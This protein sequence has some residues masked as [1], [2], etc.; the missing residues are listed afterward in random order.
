ML[1]DLFAYLEGEMLKHVSAEKEFS[2]RQRSVCCQHEEIKARMELVMK[3]CQERKDVMSNY[4]AK[5]TE[6]EAELAQVK[7]EQAEAMESLKSAVDEMKPLKQCFVDSPSKSENFIAG[8]A[9][10]TL[11]KDN[12]SFADSSSKSESFTVKKAKLTVQK[13]ASLGSWIVVKDVLKNYL[14]LE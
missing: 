5:V 9:T 11:Q 7:V 10:L 14:K 13:G 12:T 3:K 2:P 4:D 1:K 8:H 6:L